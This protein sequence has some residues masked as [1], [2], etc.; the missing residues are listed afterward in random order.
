MKNKNVLSSSSVFIVWLIC[1][2]GYKKKVVKAVYT[3]VKS[4]QIS[5]YEELERKV[6]NKYKNY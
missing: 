5:L 4:A 3:H 6:K 1:A 2:F